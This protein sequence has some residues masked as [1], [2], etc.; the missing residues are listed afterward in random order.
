MHRW[1]PVSADTTNGLINSFQQI[2]L[3]VSKGS[4]WKSLDEAT[5]RGLVRAIATGNQIIGFPHGQCIA[6]CLGFLMV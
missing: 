5:E 2:G 3:S 1:L 4:E 6:I